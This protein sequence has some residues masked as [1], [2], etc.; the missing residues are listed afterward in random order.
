MSDTEYARALLRAMQEARKV[1][2]SIRPG[3]HWGR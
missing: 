3:D 2:E 1:A